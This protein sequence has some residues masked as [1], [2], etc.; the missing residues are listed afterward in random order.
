MRQQFPL[1][2]EQRVLRLQHAPFCSASS[3]GSD[4]RRGPVPEE[5]H[6][7]HSTALWPPPAAGNAGLCL[8]DAQEGVRAILLH[9]KHHLNQEGTVGSV[10]QPELA[11]APG[12]QHC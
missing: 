1:P 7:C 4:F 6:L 2:I 5:L 12:G 10:C 8:L 11:A 3:P 9:P